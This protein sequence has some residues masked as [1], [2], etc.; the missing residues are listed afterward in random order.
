MSVYNQMHYMPCG[1]RMTKRQKNPI[2]T[3]FK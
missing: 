2:A 1:N 3:E